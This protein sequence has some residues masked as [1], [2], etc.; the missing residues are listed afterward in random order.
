[1]ECATWGSR[2]GAYLL[3]ILF[4]TVIPS[5]AGIV[6]LA[7]GVDG[8]E[9]LGAVVLIAA[10]GIAF[11]VYSAAFEARSGERA[12]QTLGKQIVGIRVVRDGGEPIGF[13]FALLRELAVR[14]L[15]IGF[16][17]GWFF[18][19]PLLNLLWPLW[20]ESNRALHD[21][22]VSTHVVRAESTR[23]EATTAGL[24]G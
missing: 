9:A 14:W 19:P 6:L 22:V 5:I 4:A 2:V 7:T 11:P 21:M 10:I 17:G 8:L 18:F 16:V 1:M 13:G 24:A 3:D 12:G 20:D 15:L 23:A